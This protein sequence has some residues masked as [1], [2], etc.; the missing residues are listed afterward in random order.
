[1]ARAEPPR[2]GERWDTAPPE[3]QLPPGRP[4]ENGDSR[5]SGIIGLLRSLGEDMGTLVRQEI[6]LAKAEA[7]RTAKRL[8]ADSVWIG[9]GATIAAVGGLCLVLAMALGLGALLGSYWL[10]TL[11]TGL[12]LVLGGALVAWKGV[13]DLRSGD[14]KPTRTIETV[15]EDVAW[16]K[17]EAKGFKDELSNKES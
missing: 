15:R 16:A 3:R 8:A 9:A 10:G 14:L 13:R 17:R 4:D 12:V 5:G 2:T 7:S 6:Q 1:M 11:I